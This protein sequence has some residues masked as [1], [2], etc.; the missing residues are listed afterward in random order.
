MSLKFCHSPPTGKCIGLL[1]VTTAIGHIQIFSLPK[2]ESNFI[3]RVLALTPSATLKLNDSV[4][5]YNEPKNQAS[6]V[7]WNK[8]KE[9]TLLAAGYVCGTVAIWDLNG[10][11]ENEEKFG[12]FIYYLKFLLD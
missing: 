3:A 7:T 10:M 8:Q 12:K 9:N 11:E 6:K 1:A 2:P 4:S 5:N